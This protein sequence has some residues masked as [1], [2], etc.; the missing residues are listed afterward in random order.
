MV[1]DDERREILSIARNAIVRGDGSLPPRVPRSGCL[2]RP[3]G[4]FVTIRLKGDLRGC[5]G[6]IESP[7]PLANV[8]AEVA[9]KSATQDPRFPPLTAPEIEE[10]V[11]EVSILSPLQRVKDIGEI[12][13]GVHGLLLE[14]GARRG[15]LL[16]QV[17]MEYG[18]NT[19][20]FLDNTCRKAGLASGSWKAPGAKLSMFTAEVCNEEHAHT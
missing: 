19:A 7:L 6:Y 17:A 20:E 10:A 8:V 16:P 14:L 12:R 15:L 11:I 1:T 9:L 4:A 3:G 13:I 5:I 18:W 2:A